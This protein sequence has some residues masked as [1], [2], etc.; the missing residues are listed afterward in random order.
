MRLMD[1]RRKYK[2]KN[3]EKYRRINGEIRRIRAAKKSWYSNKCTEIEELQKRND[4]FNMFKKVKEVL[5]TYRSTAN[6]LV[7]TR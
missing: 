6:S 5:G 1:D 7:E 2:N 3:V 4:T